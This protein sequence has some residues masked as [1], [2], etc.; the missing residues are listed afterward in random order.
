[1]KMHTDFETNFLEWYDNLKGKIKYQSIKFSKRK[2]RKQRKVKRILEKQI[3]YEKYKAQKFCD[4]NFTRLQNLEDGL[5]NIVSKEVKGAALRA[6]IQWFEEGERPTRLFLNL[7]KSRQK[8]KVMKSLLKDDG[9]VVTD[10]ETIMHELVDFY[11]NL[12]KREST[13]KNASS[14]LI[15][16]VTRLLS[17]IDTRFC[18]EGL[19]SEELFDALKSMKPDKSPGLDGLTPQFYKAFWSEWEEF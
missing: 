15:N 3:M 4:Y 9:T 10:R 1:M 2:Q 19:K 7:E 18:D 13:D 6:K 5:N 17:P 16:N 14:A 12:Y 11:K 8:V